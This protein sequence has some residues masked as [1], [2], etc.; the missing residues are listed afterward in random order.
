MFQMSQP[1]PLPPVGECESY[2]LPD[3]TLVFLATARH[4]EDQDIV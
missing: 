2:S 3:G 1:P 4:R